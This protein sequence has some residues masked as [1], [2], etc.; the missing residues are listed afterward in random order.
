MALNWDPPVSA[1]QVLGLKVCTTTTW[2]RF[3]ILLPQNKYLACVTLPY[4]IFVKD[5]VNAPFVVFRGSLYSALATPQLLGSFSC[6]TIRNHSPA[7]S[8]CRLLRAEE[9]KLFI[10]NLGSGGL[11]SPT[12][13]RLRALAVLPEVLRS[14]PS[15]YMVAHN[16]L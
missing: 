8:S 11:Q 2:L 16:H 15:N 4:F 12:A 5:D 10:G 13:Q 7:I 1:S 3:Y 9:N 6:R 14:I